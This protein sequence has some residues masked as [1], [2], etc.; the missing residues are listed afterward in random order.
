MAV[1]S[2]VRRLPLL[3]PTFPVGSDLART[4]CVPRAFRSPAVFSAR[5]WLRAWARTAI[6]G[7]LLI[8][9][10]F[11][12]YELLERLV[13]I[14][15]VPVETLFRLHVYRGIAASVLVGSWSVYNIWR[16]RRA[17]DAAFTQA[18][19]ALSKESEERAAALARTE[20][21][22]EHVFDALQDRLTVLDGEG[23]VLKANR[24]A[25]AAF[26]SDPIGKKCRQ[27]GDQC[28]DECLSKLAFTKG[29]PVIGRTL[30]TDPRT[31]RVFAV[32]AY[33]VPNPD[34]GPPL[35][36]ECA[37][38]VTVAK[39]VEAQLR[40]QEKLAALG[41]LAA[42][43]AHDIANPLASM[44]S[45]LEMLERERDLD[46]V[47]QSVGELRKQV[48]RIGRTLREMNDFARRRG[49]EASAVSVDEAI[50]DALRMVRHDPRARKILIEKDVAAGLPRLRLVED[51]LVMVLVNLLIN[52]FDAMPDG[53]KLCVRAARR[54]DGGVELS[55]VDDGAGMSDEVRRRALEPMFTT[56]ARGKGTGLGLSVS[57]DVM[58]ALGGKLELESTPGR[59][60][61]VRLGFPE[62]ALATTARRER[63]ASCPSA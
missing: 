47:H 30:R 11:V 48:G 22:T 5:Q 10:V 19:E 38:D 62:G 56:K 21:F 51:Q 39:N 12:G 13:L 2:S 55:V 6:V 33:P 42:G 63:E 31:G 46:S 15:H 60:T 17:Y 50:D 43:I 29:Q 41:V 34:G 26:G 49:E 18:Y 20:H 61:T 44:S 8:V 16:T 25:L 54:D 59:G 27:F 37:R 53:G 14:G 36:V 58:K 23:R 28:R 52:A 57:A 3:D 35:V 45:E 40:Y 24:V 7:T 1:F 32:E 9:G 4:R